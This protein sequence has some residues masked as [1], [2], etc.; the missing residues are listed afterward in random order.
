MTT[1]LVLLIDGIGADC[2]QRCL[3]R[4]PSL[5][6]MVTEGHLV[7]RLTPA[8]CATSLP[9]RAS[10]LTGYPSSKNGI[11]GNLIRKQDD[12]FGYAQPNDL[13]IPTLGSRAQ[14]HGIKV[15]GIGFGMLPQTEC[16]IY[17]PPSWAGEYGEALF[18]PLPVTMP[19]YSDRD[20]YRLRGLMNDTLLLEQ[21]V[22]AG[23][24]GDEPA[25][26]IFA[27][28]AMPD[29]L[30]HDYGEDSP[31]V[32]WNLLW[33]DAQVGLLKSWLDA[34]N[35][36]WNLVLASD[37]GHA[38]V[39]EAIYPDKIIPDGIPY[40]CEA[41]ILH[42]IVKNQQQRQQLAESMSP[43]G[44]IDIGT[45]HLP[46]DHASDMMALLAP[47]GWVFETAGNNNSKEP[48]GVSHY[49][50]SHGFYFG[51]PADDRFALFHGPDINPG[52]TD[53]ASAEQF[54]PTVALLAGLP[55]D[56]FPGTAMSVS[57]LSDPGQSLNN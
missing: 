42:L 1:L 29:Y 52:T 7:K 10:M 14:D 46:N 13:R 53:H 2:F 56:D 27:E 17:M 19:A 26:L 43:F 45:Q 34:A 25:Q 21:A 9:G 32:Q 49:R 20:N 44:V 24:T 8:T 16:D 40:A 37:H 39:Q 57:G 12:R 55:L 15:A 6:R 50:S 38:L 48:T 4:C 35:Q 31:E 36:H 3:S 33:I 47:D 28:L 54:A 11:Y 23:I 51:C 5:S 22:N 18:P 30:L 41:G